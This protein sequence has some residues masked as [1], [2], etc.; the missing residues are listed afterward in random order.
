MQGGKYRI[1]LIK[2][3]FL[4]INKIGN[5]LEEPNTYVKDTDH[6]EIR[7]ILANQKI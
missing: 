3:A 1:I 7:R 4:T 6:T 5:A 2:I